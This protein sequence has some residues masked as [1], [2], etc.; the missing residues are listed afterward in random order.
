MNSGLTIGIYGGGPL[1]SGGP[2]VIDDLRA[3]GFTTVV[4]WSVHV[5]TNGDLV[6]N[7]PPIVKGGKYVGNPVWPAQLAALKQPPTSVNRLIF[8]VGA[9]GV[10][11][12]TNVA[13][14][15]ASQGTGPSS[16]LYRNFAALRQT[17][18]EID[19]I[20]FDDEDLY[21]LPTIVKFAQMLHE[22]GFSV[23]F[24]PWTDVGFWTKCLKALNTPTDH[25]VTQFNLQCYSGGAGNDPST[26]IKAVGAAMGPSFDAKGFVFPG[27]GAALWDSK[28]KTCT[29]PNRDGYYCPADLG[30]RLAGWRT[31][32][33]QGGWV[34]LLDAVLNCQTSG[35][36]RGAMG[37]AAYAAA[38]RA[39]LT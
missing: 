31:T 1:Y 24:C 3:S 32:G 12:F 18:P 21:D 26:W 25:V 6:F 9:G 17:I 27:L 23:T 30:G 39:A 10:Q 28:A 29:M 19:A 14:L 33:I 2:G 5:E 16:V 20:D 13:K 36:C 15:I 11:D 34:W 37:T 8:S 35:I 4:A 38:V 7:D 22:I